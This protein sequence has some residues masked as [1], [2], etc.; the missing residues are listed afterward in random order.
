MSR[1]TKCTVR[2]RDSCH[3]VIGSVFVGKSA[4][5]FLV[6]KRRA[7]T[8]YTSLFIFSFLNIKKFTFSLCVLIV[9]SR[10]FFLVSSF[11]HGIRAFSKINSLFC[12]ILVFFFQALKISFSKINSVCVSSF[13]LILAFLQALKIQQW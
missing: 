9:L 2:S 10:F 7:C 12:L 11:S 4:A 6:H 5:L 13:C 1:E 8:L 3:K